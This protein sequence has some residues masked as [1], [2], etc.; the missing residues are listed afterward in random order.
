M[1]QN[2]TLFN[3][4]CFQKKSS[5]PRDALP[6][7]SE[8]TVRFSFGNKPSAVHRMKKWFESVKVIASFVLL[9]F[10]WEKET[11]RQTDRPTNRHES[12]DEQINGWI[13]F[14]RETREGSVMSKETME[15]RWT[16]RF[17]KALSLFP[18]FL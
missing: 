1:I 3:K 15:I 10:D 18:S 14:Q 7:N 12:S 6:H 11:H 13:H 17:R 8:M 9:T 2:C 4:P 5:G 16:Y